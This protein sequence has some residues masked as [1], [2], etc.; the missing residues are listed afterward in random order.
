MEGL[1]FFGRVCVSPFF[2]LDII[3]IFKSGLCL[4]VN[5]HFIECFWFCKSDTKCFPTNLFRMYP[6]PLQLAA[7]YVRSPMDS[8]CV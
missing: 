3:K 4:R 1:L 7:V 6:I 2:H 5:K 8:V